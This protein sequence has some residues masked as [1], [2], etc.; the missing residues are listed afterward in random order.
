MSTQPKL[1][2]IALF[3]MIGMGAFAANNRNYHVTITNNTAGNV[4]IYPAGDDWWYRDDFQNIQEMGAYT[5]R[6]FNSVSHEAWYRKQSGIIGIDIRYCI[7]ADV[8]CEIWYG[9]HDYSVTENIKT[10]SLGEFSYKTGI[11]TCSKFITTTISITEAHPYDVYASFTLNYHDEAESAY[12]PAARDVDGDGKADPAMISIS[13]GNWY[14][15][16]S[17]SGYARSGPYNLGLAGT[18]LLGNMDGD[19]KADPIIMDCYGNWY[20]WFSSAGYQMG[21]PYAFGVP[22]TPLA[23]DLDGDGLDDPIVQVY[24][25]SGMIWHMWPSSGNYRA[26]SFYFG[27]FGTQP[28]AGDI[29]GDR[30]ADLAAIDDSGNWTLLLSGSSYIPV[31]PVALGVA[32]KPL[33]ADSDGDGLADPIMMD[34]SE[35]WYVWSSANGFVNGGPYTLNVP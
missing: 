31:G 19:G 12:A 6:V 16:S 2:I 13:N 29:D 17:G 23:A 35:N 5:S 24:D 8:H 10:S 26:D 20:V 21:G 7:Y 15:W 30:K 18:P 4:I 11:G 34:N 22:G 9:D 33:L 1:F 3:L 27:G 14:V 32:G 28:A 25:V